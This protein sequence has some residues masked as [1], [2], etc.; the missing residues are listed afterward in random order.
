MVEKQLGLPIK[1]LRSD[2]GGE[3]CNAKF[4]QYLKDE[5]I[6][7]QTSVVYCAQQNA[8]SERLN[9]TLVE[10]A[11]CMLQEAGLSKRYWGE[12]IM[13]AIYIKNRC[14]TSALAGLTPEEKWTGSKPDLSH[15]HVF[16]C[17]AYSLVPEQRRR[18]FDAKSKMYIFVG[19][20]ETSKG[21]RLMNPSNPRQVLVSRNVAFIE[22][23]YFKNVRDVNH[24]NLNDSHNLVFYES[25]CDNDI[26]DINSRLNNIN[27]VGSSEC[28]K[29]DS[30]LSV[31]PNLSGGCVL[32]SSLSIEQNLSSN[33]ELNSSSGNELNSNSSS[34]TLEPNSSPLGQGS[35]NLIKETT[36]NDLSV[37]SDSGEDYCTGSENEAGSAWSPQSAGS[38][39][40]CVT[41]PAGSLEKEDASLG[42]SAVDARPVR[43]SRGKLPQRYDDFDVDF[44][45]AAQNFLLEEP[46][47]FEEAMSSQNAQQWQTAMQSEYDSLISNKVWQLVDRPPRE[48]VVKCKWVYKIKY[49]AAG[50][51][52]KFKARLVAR[53]FTQ[54]PVVRHSTMRI[55]FSLANEMNLDISHVDVTT[56]FLNGELTETIY[57]EQ[58]PAYT[59]ADWANDPVDRRS[60]TGFVI[61]LGNNV[62]NWESRKQRCV[63]LS[64]T[65][66]EYLAI[67]DVC[68]RNVTVV[69]QATEATFGVLQTAPIFA[70]FNL[71]ALP[72]IPRVFRATLDTSE[73]E[74]IDTIQLPQQSS[75]PYPTFPAEYLRHPHPVRAKR[76][77]DFRCLHFRD[78][79]DMYKQNLSHSE[80]KL[81]K[82]QPVLDHLNSVFHGKDVGDQSIISNKAAALGIKTYEICESQT[83]YLCGLWFTHVMSIS[84]YGEINNRVAMISTYHGNA[85]AEIKGIPNQLCA[86][87]QLHDGGVDKKDQMLAAFPIERKRTKV[88]YKKLFRRLLNVSVLNAYVISARGAVR[89]MVS[90]ANSQNQG[91]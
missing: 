86:R 26:S 37:I 57:M 16:G 88:W 13:T 72:V 47:T 19:Y 59:D 58:P 80:A 30:S 25:I 55:L 81:F 51:L 50:E 63:A 90:E 36:N 67:G 64:S 42:T 10:K 1:V 74:P 14:P 43:S 66:A 23:K 85:T 38:H 22:N 20:S 12:A 45:L 79:K 89:A 82:I 4:E 5:G 73:N 76:F 69:L 49:N 91:G 32:D 83:G 41:S 18:K 34:H 27:N 6:I 77:F 46:L 35:P 39:H 56:A 61:K 29:L 15:L 70:A 21:F 33:C 60:Y 65:E 53:G 44:S 68:S 3:Y 78:N 2:N 62:I 87:L 28:A 48:N 9:R 75:L 11:R 17:I 8:V 84:W 24:F 40:V 7:H 31:E 54:V 71:V 52:D